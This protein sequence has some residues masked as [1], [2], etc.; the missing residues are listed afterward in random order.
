[1]KKSALILGLFVSL[2]LKAWTLNPAPELKNDFKIFTNIALELDKF[3]PAKKAQVI[4]FTFIPAN[5]LH[6]FPGESARMNNPNWIELN[7]KIWHTLNLK[8]KEYLLLHEIGHTLRLEHSLDP[9]DI[10]GVNNLSYNLK[11]ARFW[12]KISPICKK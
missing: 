10:M 1:M 4:N 3:C 2:N 5:L 12:A 6:Y 7:P 9:Q 8:Q 11:P